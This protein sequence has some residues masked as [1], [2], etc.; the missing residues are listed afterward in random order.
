MA[1][2]I[3]LVSEVAS[4]A[5][6]PEL[7]ANAKRM[8]TRHTDILVD[9]ARKLERLLAKRRKLNRDMRAL[10]RAIKDARRELNA[11]TDELTNKEEG[12]L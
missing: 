6:S 8:K 12:E 2:R 10:E 1:K 7:F 11:I 5:L 9:S 3:K 4:A